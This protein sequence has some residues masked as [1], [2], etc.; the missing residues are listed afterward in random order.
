MNWFE[1][2]AE[3]LTTR[4]GEFPWLA[5]Q[6]GTIHRELSE[7]LGEAGSC[8]GGDPVGQ[9]FAAAHV[10]PADGTLGRLGSLPDQLGLVGTRFADTGTA[11]RT[12]DQAGAEN[13]TAADG[14]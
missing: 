6:A 7:A 12:Q 4:A 8:W 1:A 5:E 10:S 2:D 9:S 14:S 13:L 11:Y 3:A